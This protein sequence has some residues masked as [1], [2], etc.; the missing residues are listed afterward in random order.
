MIEPDALKKALEG[1]EKDKAKVTEELQTERKK[2]E[3]LTKEQEILN[4][5]LAELTRKNAEMQ[6][7]LAS[8]QM[9]KAT[10]NGEN[11]ELKKAVGRLER[12]EAGLQ[13]RLAALEK[14]ARD[15]KTDE[16]ITDLRRNLAA[17]HQEKVALGQENE[18]LKGSVGRLEREE[19][20]LRGRIAG[21]EKEIRMP[22]TGAESPDIHTRL[23]SI[24]FEKIALSVE[25]E[26]LRT[27]V[28][29]LEKE[30]YETRNRIQILE[31][32]LQRPKLLPEELTG[33]LKNALVKME[34]GLQTTGGRVGY[35]VGRFDADI[36][37]SLSVDKDNNFAMKLPYPGEMVTPESLSSIKLSFSAV[38]RMDTNLVGVPQCTGMS[39][40]TAIMEIQRAGLNVETKERPSP[41]P[42][43]TVFNQEPE[44]YA[45]VP[46]KST[47]ML[48][49][50]IPET[51]IIPKL[52]GMR[53]DDAL[54]MIIDN[55]LIAGEIRQELSAEPPDLVLG[56][57]PPEG[58][59]VEGMSRVDLVISRE[60]VTVPKLIDQTEEEAKESLRKASLKAG[61]IRYTR[62][63]NPDRIVVEQSPGADEIVE[64]G[65]LVI[66]TIAQPVSIAELR[67]M[68]QSDEEAQKN[69]K[70]FQRTLTA[71]DRLEIQN[72]DE[73]R[74]LAVVSDEDLKRTLGLQTD[75][76]AEKV[77]KVI[78]RVFTD[79]GGT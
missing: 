5:S 61:E 46:L 39:K 18:E 49:L 26:Q 59:E 4:T 11:E 73:I 30:E 63:Q 34:E 37:A 36:K 23:A 43:G 7:Q 19:A 25:N 14:E 31:R 75:E 40:E 10:L 67:S 20:L 69:E 71:M 21:L 64:P 29:R 65:S 15:T 79:L 8:L 42:A 28:A 78:E 22:E 68:I 66:L 1:V 24:K 2:I 44:A 62:S 6:K 70:L 33:M 50:S 9:E 32:E 77:R 56:Q 41:S 27:A 76:E 52:T 55:H 51:V 58:A 13:T 17:L 16:E 48:T 45:E 60:G 35:I 53:K 3:S 38:P 57:N 72:P 47:V 54:R 74:R 12:E